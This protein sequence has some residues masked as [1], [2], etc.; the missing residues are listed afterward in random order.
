MKP[1][2]P[3]WR[4]SISTTTAGW[5]FLANGAIFTDPTPK[6]SIPRKTGPRD[7][8]R[9]FHQK[10][11]G[12]FEDVT[13]KPGLQGVGFG[14]GVAVG[15]FDN[16]GYEDL[17][18]T[19]YGGN[20]LYRNNGDGTFTDVTEKAGVGGTGWSTSAAWVDLDNDGLL[21][22]VVLRY[23]QWDF[24][25]IW[26]GEHRKAIAPTAI[27]IRSSRLRRWC[28]T[29]TATGSSPKLRRKLGIT[30]R[31]RVWASP[32]RITIATAAS[33]SRRQRFHAGVPLSQKGK[34]AF[35]E[36][37]LSSR[38]R[39][40]RTA[41]PTPAWGSISPIT[42]MTG[43]R[44]WSITDLANQIYALYRND[45]DGSFSYASKTAGLG[46]M[47]LLHS[48]WGLRFLDYR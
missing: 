1:W 42:T 23:V 45:G 33:I 27:P 18:V 41:A 30:G 26:C 6:G 16:D 7:W 12:T 5:I 11:D 20:H 19:G 44:I 15:D 13:E 38:S 4:S 35:E 40:M 3:A 47:T 25:D 10:A 8:N 24:D 21:D 17:Y 39:W 37:G 14:M 28:F 29:T 36:N 2:V 9:L 48:G 31:A 32:S 43:C 22:L 34:G 46:A